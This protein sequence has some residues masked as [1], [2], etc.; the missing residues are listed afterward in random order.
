M[1]NRDNELRRI[2][3]LPVGTFLAIDPDFDRSKWQIWRLNQ[4]GDSHFQRNRI[5]R[6]RHGNTQLS[7]RAFRPGKLL[8]GLTPARNLVWFRI[9]TLSKNDPGSV[10][11]FGWL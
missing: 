1:G 8:L 2:A 11:N 3:H 10:G 4:R 9:A 6:H 7:R 5:L